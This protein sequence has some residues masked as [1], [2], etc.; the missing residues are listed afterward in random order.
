M[1]E[2]CEALGQWVC[3]C[4]AVVKVNCACDNCGSSEKFGENVAGVARSQDEWGPLGGPA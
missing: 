2:L 1:C 4:G 3:W